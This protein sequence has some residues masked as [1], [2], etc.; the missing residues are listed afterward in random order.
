[1]R[2][3]M[4]GAESASTGG[5]P[6]PAGGLFDAAGDFDSFLTDSLLPVLGK[7][8]PHAETVL[9]P[10]AMDGLLAD[11]DSALNR[12]RPGPEERGLRRLQVLAA[13]CRADVS[14]TLVFVSD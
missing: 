8:D 14:S 4:R 3:E 12:A 5:H 11:V 2:V 9:L 13:R 10:T 7:V 6:D 1:M